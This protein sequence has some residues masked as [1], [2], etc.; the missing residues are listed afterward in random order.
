[1]SKIRIQNVGPVKD[2]YLANDGWMDIS[3][4]TVFIGNQGSGKS[5]VA[6]LIST[7]TWMEKALVRGDFGNKEISETLFKR[8]IGYQNIENYLSDNSVIEY[9]GSAYIISYNK[10]VINVSKN[11]LNGYS[12]PK[13][14]YVPSERNFLSSV[15]NVR[16]LKGLP[17]TLYTFSDEFSDALENLK[18]P[19]KLP[20][21]NTRFEYQKRN[22]SSYISGEDY[23]VNLMQASSG[24]QSFVPLFIVSNY[25]ANSLNSKS[26][27]GTS[28]ISIDQSR[29]IRKEIEELYANPNI[30]DE[31]RKVSLEVLSKGFKYSS[32]IN[33][34]EEPEQ[35]L[36]PTSQQHLLNSL[37]GFKN[38]QEDNKLILTTHSPYIVNYLSI[39]IQAGS[40]LKRNLPN[41][42]L[43]K[44]NSVVPMG[45]T[46]AAEEVSVYQFDELKGRITDLPDFEGI[47][48]DTN[49]LNLSL[50]AGNNAF[51]TL[52]EIEQEL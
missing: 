6:K 14:M 7:M 15:R 13:I 11:E 28:D 33:I 38:M 52:L 4:V 32:F 35:N 46:L 48:S 39:A 21:N 34:V 12:F 19:L 47:P 51:D 45:S 42:L 18:G 10:G 26:D 22:L 2:G 40:L 9:E 8:H 5:T 41:A 36:F 24:F 30:S 17:S 50:A 27:S 29:R 37:I 49:F 23:K 44:L 31:I 25:L 1:M 20:I 16:N 3:D 43:S